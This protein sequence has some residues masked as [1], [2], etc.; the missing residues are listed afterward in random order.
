MRSVLAQ[1][2]P[3][4][5][6]FELIV[7]DNNSSDATAAVVERFARDDD[8]VRYVFESRQGLSHA[9]N[10]GIDA[11]RASLVAFT[12]DDVRADPDW[13]GAIVRAFSTHPDIDMVGGRVLPIWP[14]LPPAWLTRRHWAPLALVDYGEQAFTITAD[15]PKCLVGAN[16]ACRRAL[17]DTVGVFATDFQRV[18][19]GIGS[20]EDH[21]FMLRL[22]RAGRKALYDP[23]LTIRA[24]IQ[25]NRLEPTYHRRWHRGH[26]HF[27][28]LLHSP[29]MER[30]RVGTLFDVPAHLYRQA[31]GDALGWVGA[32]ATGRSARAFD[33]EMRLRFFAGFLTTR[34]SEF[35]KRRLTPREPRSRT[36]RITG[37]RQLSSEL[38]S[39][40][41]ARSRR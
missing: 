3:N 30:T 9:R 21:E 17:F 35:L 6:P 1:Q 34:G 4:T 37:P 29:E 27:H 32:F 26:G 41:V 39:A 8:R 31:V 28:A 12:D 16:L 2:A 25:P 10:A 15:Q 38:T 20:L 24:E 23:R 36:P 22:W 11:A 14:A 33:H 13:V 19:D 7:V 18:K 5:P 40:R